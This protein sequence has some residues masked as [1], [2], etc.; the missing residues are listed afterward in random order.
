M[1][2]LI[3]FL[4]IS[5]GINIVLFIPAF[6]FKTDKITDL[7][8][9]LSFIAVA[10][11]GLFFSDHSIFRFILALMVVVWGLRLGI[12]LFIRIRKMNKD[13]RFDGV[14]ENFIKFL[15]FWLLQAVAVWVILIPAIFFLLSGSSEVFWA[16]LGV[17]AFGLIIEA[18]ADIE[19]Y[20]FRQDEKNK[21]RFI[22][23]GLW[24]Y[25]RHPNY[26]GEILCWAGI[27]VFVFPALT[28]T[29]KLYSLASPLFITILL[30]FVTGI[31]PLEK[32][33]DEKWGNEKDYQEYKRKTSILIPWFPR[34]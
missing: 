9:S 14:R 8:Y 13:K 29:Q 2:E 24:R 5:L 12:F 22:N 34:R 15:R 1:L 3:D 11:I 27:Y 19:K 33:A 26:F 4:L 31:P 20:M 30:L 28:G 10:V 32:R 17:W 21:G 6:I 16:G 18:A 7:S 23:T 25:S